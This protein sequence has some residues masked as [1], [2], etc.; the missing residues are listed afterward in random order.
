MRE[1][2]GPVVATAVIVTRGDV[3]LEPILAS[4][5]AV[6][7]IVD[8]VVW[9]NSRNLDLKVW[10]RHEALRGVDTRVVYSQDDDIVYTPEAIDRIL[11]AYVPGLAVGCMYPEWSA[12]A[13]RSGIPGGYADLV[14]PGSGAVYDRETPL[15]AAARY[16]EHHPE[17][18]FFR[19]WCDAVIG[20]LAPTAAHGERF[21][22]LPAA[23][24]ADRLSRRPN[25]VKDK[26]EAILR[27]RRIRGAA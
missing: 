25:A 19:L 23:Y 9:D 18:E 2:G 24:G 4:L 11:D 5:R 8:L 10:G 21:E 26:R 16:L 13:E 6:P 3:E 20:V 12:Q 1:G 17:D 27:A 15:V 22:I 7:R 14:Y